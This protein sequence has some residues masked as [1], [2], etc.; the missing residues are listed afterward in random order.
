MTDYL[1]YTPAEY[2]PDAPATALHFQ[3]WFQNWEAGFAGAPGAPRLNL[4]ALERPTAGAQ[5]RARY[6]A[7]QTMNGSTAITAIDFQFMQVGTVRLSFEHK[8]SS[9][10]GNA[11]VVRTRNGIDVDLASF[12]HTQAFVARQVDI[13][14]I[15]GDSVA[16][17][18]NSGGNT[19]TAS[20]QNCRFSTNGENLYR[21]IS[22]PVEGNIYA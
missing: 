3:R 2:A 22:G 8:C 19:P 14:V 15:P 1:A 5:I 18:Y 11:R 12:A 20:V 16:L 9:N 21:G 10:A 7:L 13:P 17:K 6:D 4:G